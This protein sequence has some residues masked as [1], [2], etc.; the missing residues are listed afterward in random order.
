MQNESVMNDF[1]DTIVKDSSEFF[2]YICRYSSVGTDHG[3]WY[4]TY[5][6]SAYFIGTL[7]TLT[8][9]PGG[10]YEDKM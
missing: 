1:D 9:F 2:C 8:H 6:V 3:T 5:G 10:D 7:L 4:N